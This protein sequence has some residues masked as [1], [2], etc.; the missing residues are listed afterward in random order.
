MPRRRLKIVRGSEPDQPGSLLPGAIE[1][2]EALQAEIIR[3]VE[4]GDADLALL[5]Y[6]IDNALVEAR[7]QLR[8]G[9]H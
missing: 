7:D 4:A 9:G 8:R 6:L 3:A 2:L 1:K 5:V